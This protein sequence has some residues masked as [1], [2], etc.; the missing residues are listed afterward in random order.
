[1]E[2]ATPYDRIARKIDEQDPHTAP[3]AEDGS[4]H[5]AFIKHS[6]SSIRPRRRRSFSI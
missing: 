1:M 2:E 5:E 6:S 4:I 3:K